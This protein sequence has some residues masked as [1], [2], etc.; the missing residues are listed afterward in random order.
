MTIR[1]AG[2]GSGWRWEPCC[3]YLSRSLAWD[4]SLVFLGSS[5]LLWIDIS[6]Q[7]ESSGPTPP[8][9]LWTHAWEHWGL[10]VV[11][12]LR[13]PK[14]TGR[15]SYRFLQMLR[16]CEIPA[17]TVVCGFI[18]CDNIVNYQVKGTVILLI[19]F[20]AGVGFVLFVCFGWAIEDSFQGLPF[21]QFVPVHNGVL[22]GDPRELTTYVHCLVW[23]S[24]KGQL[25]LRYPGVSIWKAWTRNQRFSNHFFSSWLSTQKQWEGTGS[26]INLQTQA[27]DIRK[28]QGVGI[29]SGCWGEQQRQWT[30]CELQRIN[31]QP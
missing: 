1:K 8:Q 21:F 22:K 14:G 15:F 10:S 20:Q 16:H 3:S 7:T 25:I 29:S 19:D 26:K 27:K 28:T 24:S 4:K 18:W 17:G 6:E 30:G 11:S 2:K 13:A 23:S 12:G 9:H 31:M 5:F